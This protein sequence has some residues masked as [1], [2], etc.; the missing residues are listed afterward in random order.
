MVI[1]ILDCSNGCVTKV[2]LS[3]ER[4]QELNEMLDTNVLDMSDFI[5]I[6][7]EEFGVCAQS[8]VW[9]STE[10]DKVYEVEF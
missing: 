9:M 8:S 1:W 2:K 4:E 3:A 7:E 5:S 10:S 6:H